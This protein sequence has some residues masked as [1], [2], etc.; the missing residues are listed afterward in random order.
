MNSG[1][2]ASLSA[3]AIHAIVFMC[4]HHCIHGNTALSI[5]VG[6][7]S[8][9]SS[10]FFSGFE[11][12]HLLKINAHLGHLSDLWVVVIITWNPWSSGFGNNHAAINHQT[13]DISA[14]AVAHTS[15]AISLN[16]SKSNVFV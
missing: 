16:L 3:T 4:G 8:I 5:L 1:V 11:T 14:Y 10:G 9:V 15:F 12:T 6:I 13:C 2:S 7:F